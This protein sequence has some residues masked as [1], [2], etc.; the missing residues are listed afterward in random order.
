MTPMASVMQAPILTP[1]KEGF[2]NE[3]EDG[4][5][6]R[7]CGCCVACTCTCVCKGCGMSANLSESQLCPTCTDESEEDAMRYHER[8]HGPGMF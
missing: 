5:W 2:F 7:A 6:C 1:D 3:Q 8:M 4:P